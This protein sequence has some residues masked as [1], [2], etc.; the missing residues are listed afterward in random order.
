MI[1][2]PGSKKIMPAELPDVQ[3]EADLRGMPI[4]KVGVNGVKYPVTVLDKTDKK[5]RTVAD[6]DMYVDLPKHFRG[7]HMSRFLE[8]LNEHRGLITMLNVDKI[9]KK[10]RKKFGAASAHFSMK[11]TYFIEKTSPVSKI[12]SLLNYDCEFISSYTDDL[13][14]VLGVSIPVNT[15]CPCSKEIS[16]YGAHNQRSFINIHVRFN[17]FIWIE[18]IVGI[19]ERSA[20]S[21]IYSLLKRSDEKYLTEMS[22]Q[23][24]RFVEDVVREAAVELDRDENITWFTVEVINMESIHAHNAYAIIKKDK[25]PS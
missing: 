11:F 4:D 18:D 19:A 14:F 17:D 10:M 25:R 16:A 6:I 23:N 12:K 5:Q 13:D 21:P 20:S 3:S 15:L 9:L 2:K 7:T 8:I 24:P 22:Y 1:L